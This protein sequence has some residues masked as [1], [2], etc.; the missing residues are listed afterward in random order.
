MHPPCEDRAGEPD[1]GRDGIME[2]KE[3]E[4]AHELEIA[5]GSGAHRSQQGE[6]VR[7]G[8]SQCRRRPSEPGSEY[9]RKAGGSGDGG[10]AAR[11]LDPTDKA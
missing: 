1:G 2:A 5:R 3:I 10:D 8:E 11:D 4:A 7:Q 6:A 9:R